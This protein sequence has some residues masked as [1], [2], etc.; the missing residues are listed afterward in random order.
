MNA[1]VLTLF[2][3]YIIIIEIYCFL[4][5]IISIETKVLLLQTKVAVADFGYYV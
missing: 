4:N 1:K 2:I 3:R 5:N